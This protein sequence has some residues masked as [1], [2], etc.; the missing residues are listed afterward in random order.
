MPDLNNILAISGVV[1]KELYRRKDFYVLFILTAII[2]LAFASMNFFG[3]DSII[4]YVKEICLSL[5]LLSSVVIGIV[6]AARQI[7][8][9]R[10]SRTIFPLLAKPVTRNEVVLGKFLGTWL[11]CGITLLF[12]YIFFAIV[13]ASKEHSLPIANYF[14]LITMQWAMLGIVISMA[15]LGSVI[16]AAPSSNS[17]IVFVAVT[18]ILV[19]GRHLNKFAMNMSEP[20]QS[21]VYFL[22]TAIPHLEFYDV[23]DLV[24][25]NWP[26]IGWGPW[27]LALIYAGVYMAIFLFATCLAFRRKPLEAQ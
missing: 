27:F 23:R 4:R 19:L 9:E 2:T 21:L 5:I 20:G 3:E 1:V 18:F 15:T 24:V 7:P 12:F 14:Q 10:E 13:S 17:T 25:H 16:F 8:Q 22:Y 6:T 11:A 26:H